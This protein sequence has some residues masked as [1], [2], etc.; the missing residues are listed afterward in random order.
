MARSDVVTLIPLDRAA[1]ILGIDPYHFNMITTLRRPQNNACDDV[2]FQTADQR[3]GQASRYDLSVAL[4]EAEQQTMKYLGYSPMPAWFSDEEIPISQPYAVELTNYRGINSKGKPKSIRASM[5]YLLEAGVRAKSLIDA[6]ASVV[7]SDANGD[8]YSELATVTVS[9]SVT[10]P[11]EIHAYFAGEDG[12]DGWEI[13]PISVSIAAGVAT[14]TF[15]K[16]LVPLPDLWVRDPSEDDPQWRTI[17]GDISTNFVEKIDVYRVYT[18]TTNQATLYYEN[19]CLSCSGSGCSLCAFNST[20]ACLRIRDNRLG[21]FSY[22]PATWDANT[23]SFVYPDSC[24]SNPVKIKI[25]YRAGYINQGTNAKPKHPYNQ[26]D[27]MWERAIVYYAFTMVDRAE[28]ICGNTE[29]VYSRM[30]E[31]LALNANGRSFAMS[32][33]HMQSPFGTTRAAIDLW[34]M[35]ERNR[36]V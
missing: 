29:N 7:Y 5:G 28:N 3:I 4:F 12:E 22:S 18:D 25:N 21:L 34:R 35:V 17:D 6:E 8:G 16:Y 32:F 13:R 30:S 36:M 23:A 20:G 14:I 15:S 31:D 1:Q 33:K 11:Q 27:A 19:N 24:Y 26:M 10:D 9:T 2:W